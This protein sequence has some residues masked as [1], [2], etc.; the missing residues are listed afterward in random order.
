[1]LS[2]VGYAVVSMIIVFFLKPFLRI[3]RSVAAYAFPFGIIYI[4]LLISADPI[5]F[6]LPWHRYLGVGIGVFSEIIFIFG[7]LRYNKRS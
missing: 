7:L 4:I 3:D 5:M 6:D 1:M 2:L